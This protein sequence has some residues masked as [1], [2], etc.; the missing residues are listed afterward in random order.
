MHK[1]QEQLDQATQAY[2]D[3]LQALATARQA[4]EEGPGKAFADMLAVQADLKAKI[5]THEASA[6]EAQAT[7]KRLFAKAGHVV[8]KEVKAALSAKNDA[9]ALSED[10]ALEPRITASA[11]AKAY[12]IA[13]AHARAAYARVEV[14]R[15]LRECGEAMGRAVALA[16]H[17]P[18]NPDIERLT[19]DIDKLR[20]AFV[21]DALVGVARGLS[22]WD[23]VPK[24]EAIGSL[25]LGP[26]NDPTQ[27]ISTV[28][29]QVARR[30]LAAGEDQAGT[31]S[32]LRE[33]AA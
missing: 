22:E 9:L 28:A 32:E 2:K 27:F 17:I 11:A 21:W 30:K 8:T 25:D 26:F 4:H 6:D 14:W 29:A 24:V 13:Y 16:A 12:E 23:R 7:F 19:T 10:S 3:A 18:G 33:A 5:A 1:I 15:T 31:E 20:T